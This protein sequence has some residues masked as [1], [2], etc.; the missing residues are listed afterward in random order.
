MLLRRQTSYSSTWSTRLSLQ[1]E[2]GDR[3]HEAG[4]VVYWSKYSYIAL[5]LKRAREGEGMEVV[6]RWIDE[7]NDEV[8]VSYRSS[9]LM[10]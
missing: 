7:E 4:V 5:L 2:E 9:A 8:K 1:P 6:V 10:V 3:G